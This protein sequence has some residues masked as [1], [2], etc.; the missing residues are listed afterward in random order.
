MITERSLARLY[1]LV[2]KY[3]YQD[4]LVA[5]KKR[6]KRGSKTHAPYSLSDATNEARE[7]YQLA[8]KGDRITPDEENR[9]KAYLLKK[10]MLGELDDIIAAENEG[11]KYSP[12]EKVEI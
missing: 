2:A 7:M 4:I 5:N 1:N 11:R 3:A 6:I 10:N 9:V 8:L 12:S